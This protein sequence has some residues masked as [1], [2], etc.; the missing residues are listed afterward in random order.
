MSNLTATR[1]AL[2]EAGIPFREES[3]MSRFW[4]TRIIITKRA[5]AIKAEKVLKM[6]DIGIGRY[7]KEYCVEYF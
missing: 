3:F 7:F 2:I 4:G 1:N 5:D 6:T